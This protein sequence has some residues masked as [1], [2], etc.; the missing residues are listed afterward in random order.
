L[1]EPERDAVRQRILDAAQ[2]LFDAEGIQAVSMRAIGGRVGL[3]ASA[4]YAYFPAKMDLIRALWRGTLLDL[5]RRLREMS[6]A[7]SDPIRN[8]VNLGLAYAEFALAE[9]VRFRLLFLSTSISDLE[10]ESAPETRAAYNL[11]RERTAEAIA[12]GRLRITDADLASQ[13]LWSALHGV[14]TLVN[15]CGAFPLENPVV[16]IRTMIDTVLRG[17]VAGDFEGV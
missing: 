9:P 7:E 12:Q 10:F 14:L 17:L 16:L 3:T 5:E 13:T 4:L 8:L 6:A 15:T 1:T 11:L 2:E